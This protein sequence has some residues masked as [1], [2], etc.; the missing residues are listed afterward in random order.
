MPP[1][2]TPRASSIVEW[3]LAAAGIIGVLWAAA[4]WVRPYVDPAL[5]THTD[6]FAGEAVPEG[7]PS[8]AVST[9][10]LVLE[11]GLEVRVG[12]SEQELA[13][14]VKH[15]EPLGQPQV[16]AGA[17]GRRTLRAF[18]HQRTRFYVVSES[19]EPDGPVRVSGVFVP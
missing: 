19:T 1:S 14:A 5:D 4:S 16:S 8:G 6:V 7:V 17:Y 11:D 12:M 9:P 15:C 10:L 2:P 18:A 3:L 13:E